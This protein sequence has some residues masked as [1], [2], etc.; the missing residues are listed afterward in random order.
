[1]TISEVFTKYG[2]K[3]VHWGA[4]NKATIYLMDGTSIETELEFEL[5]QLPSGA[6]MKTDNCK[7]DAL[8]KKL[9]ANS[10]EISAFQTTYKT[11]MAAYNREIAATAEVLETLAECGVSSYQVKDLPRLKKTLVTFVMSD[12]AEQPVYIET[13]HQAAEQHYLAE[14]MKYLVEHPERWAKP[15]SDLQMSVNTRNRINNMPSSTLKI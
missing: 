6:F 11:S 12:R 8:E 3:N 15:C 4:N 2:I 5:E 7:A 14:A 13:Q 10:Y 1:M 9:S